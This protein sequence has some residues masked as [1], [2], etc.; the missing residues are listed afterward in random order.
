MRKVILLLI[1]FAACAALAVD[2]QH[3]WVIAAAY[4]FF[5]AILALCARKAHSSKSESPSPPSALD[6]TLTQLGFGGAA[7]PFSR[8]P[9][10]EPVPS[11]SRSADTTEKHLV[12]SFA[13]DDHGT[14]HGVRVL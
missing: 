9:V 12:I 3:G 13:V 2:V 11:W 7:C 8:N 1:P 5:L 14:V 10:D 4:A 6:R